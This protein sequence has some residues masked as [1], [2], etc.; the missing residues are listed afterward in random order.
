[1]LSHLLPLLYRFLLMLAKEKL[2]KWSRRR[3]ERDGETDSDSE[4]DELTIDITSAKTAEHVG[5]E[6]PCAAIN[7]K[8]ASEPLI[9]RHTSTRSVSDPSVQIDRQ[10][11]ESELRVLAARFDRPIS[12]N[13]A[14]TDNPLGLTLVHCP[15]NPLFDLIFVHGLGGTSKGTWSYERDQRHFWPAWLADDIGLSACRTFTFG[16]NAAFA[17]QYSSAGILDFA[18]DLLFRMKTF[19]GESRDDGP[20]IGKVRETT[21]VYDCR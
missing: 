10:G 16:Y 21:V 9:S 14:S 19:S 17:A 13:T 20:Q 12:P 18:K 15:P 1:M 2:R 4:N 6:L 7:P 8:R 11:S 3:S 5:L